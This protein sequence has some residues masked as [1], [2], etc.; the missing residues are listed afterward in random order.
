M[1]EIL[2]LNKGYDF[3]WKKEKKK[4]KLT[5]SFQKNLKIPNYNKKG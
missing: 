5:L 4:K 1:L 3:L 2:Y